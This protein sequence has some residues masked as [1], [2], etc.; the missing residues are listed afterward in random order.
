MK[1][2]YS[3]LFLMIT[4]IANSFAQN[5]CSTPY[6][7][8]STMTG[9]FSAA[10]STP[11]TDLSNN[12][13]CISPADNAT[14][15]YFQAC[16]SGNID[17]R[18]L[19]TSGSAADVDF[20]VWGPLSASTDCGLTAGQIID[21]STSSGILDTINV[22]GAIAGSYYKILISN[23]LNYNIAAQLTNISP[24]MIYDTLCTYCAGSGPIPS[25]QICQVTTDL[26]LNQNIIIWEKD[27]LYTGPYIIQKESTTMG[28]YN[29]LATVMN[30]DTSAYVDSVSN[31]MIQ[32][33][34][35]R[36]AIPDT[37]GF[38]T[39]GYGAPHTTI[40]LLTSTSSSTGYPQLSWNSYIGFGYGTYY[41][42][43]GASP[44]SLTLYDSISAS[45]NSYTDVA[46]VPGMNYY[47][48]SVLPPAPCQP[49]RAMTMNSFSNVSP[50]MFTGI[51]EYEFNQLTVGPNPAFDVLN[52]SLGSASADVSVDIIDVTGRIILSKTFENVNQDAISLNEISNGSYVVRFTSENKTTHR[53]I[54][55]AK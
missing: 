46:A 53:N 52:F 17:I 31:P 20:I 14:W 23:P 34:K 16:T 18:I 7:I 35:Y 25:Q 43:R 4:F 41:I 1:K 55:I 30:N 6:P 49:S 5:T 37:C 11:N 33:F 32:A 10:M 8:S 27:T 2:I 12:Y 50:V 13:G 26:L 21:C 42:Y 15:L 39:I 48:V 3:L 19:C 47:S 38:G 51:N 29:T 9:Y 44:T 36:I 54:I 24:G 28:I 40:H 22:I 45:F